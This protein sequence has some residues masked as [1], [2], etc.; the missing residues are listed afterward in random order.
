MWDARGLTAARPP[1]RSVPVLLIVRVCF[2]N[3]EERQAMFE[4][5]MVSSLGV[6]GRSLV[7]LVVF[8]VFGVVGVS[9]ALAKEPSGDFA[10][11]KQCPRFS[12]GVN[13]CLYSRLTGG[14]VTLGKQTVPINA[15]GQHEVIMQGGIVQQEEPPFAETFVGA[16]NGETLSRT[17]QD[18]PGGLGGLVNCQ[19]IGY[20]GF[21]GGLARALCRALLLRNRGAGGLR[22]TTELALPASDITISKRNLVAGEGTGLS[23]PVKIHLEGPLLGNHCYIGSSTTPI[24][25]NLTTGTTSPQKPNEPIT[26][27]IGQIAAK[28]EFEFVEVPGTILVNNEFAA[29]EATGCGGILSFLIDPLINHKIGLPSPDGNNTTIQNT[30]IYEATTKGVINSEQ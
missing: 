16:L 3:G 9:S 27:A 20:R 5:E 15:D 14:S 13:L 24:V 21:L 18:V 8:V 6:R 10:L 30:N 4:S 2:V 17:P 1:Y 25:L 12:P 22:A 19:E 7:V 28:D 26:G 11:F 23:L 29:P